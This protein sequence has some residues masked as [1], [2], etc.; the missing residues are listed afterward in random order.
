MKQL[1]ALTRRL[2]D[3]PSPSGDEWEAARFIASHLESLGYRVELQEVAPRRA[4]VIAAAS[5][6]PRLFFSTHIDT[7]PPFI[8]S[9]E[10]DT[11]IHGRGSCD[12]KGIMAAQI[13]AAERLRAEGT[14]DVGLLFTVDEELGSS[15]ARAANA[16]AL[17]DSCAY[18]INGE[19]TENKLAAGSKGSLRVRLSTRGRAAHSAYPEQ[20]DSAIER[21]LDV[22]ARIRAHVWPRDDFFGETTCN[23]GTLAGGTRPNIIPAEAQ[24]ELQIRLVTESAR[25]KAELERA[26][27]ARAEIEYLSVAEPVRLLS[28]EGFAS[29]VV[30]FTTDIPY[31]PN[32]G[33]P[34]LLGPGSI[35][36]AHTADER[37][38]K[39]ELT[40]AVELYA[41]L[42]ARLLARAREPLGAGGAANFG[43][44]GA[45]NLNAGTDSP[46]REGGGTV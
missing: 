5:P 33:A 20:G 41:R 26:V 23:I 16:H 46:A 34:L 30:R 22:L 31:L 2:I 19:P 6:A 38:R 10:D 12:A 17:A 36:D 11:H 35:L 7:V 18:L 8:A 13:F 27:D 43:A 4:N 14:N 1:Y 25:V 44:G 40:A 42:A 9:R 37:I 3:I 15:G 29:E 21:L 28:V 39:D 24:A 32:W 45:A